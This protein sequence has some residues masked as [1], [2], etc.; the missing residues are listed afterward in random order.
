MNA[1]DFQIHHTAGT[2]WGAAFVRELDLMIAANEMASKISHEP[3]YN[4]PFHHALGLRLAALDGGAELKR[5]PDVDLVTSGDEITHHREVNA[6]ID[7][8]LLDKPRGNWA[9][10]KLSG[11]EGDRYD[12]YVSNGCGRAETEACVKFI[13]SRNTVP[14]FDDHVM[15]GHTLS[16]WAYRRRI[17]IANRIEEHCVTAAELQVG[18]EV[19]D[20]EMNGKTFSRI[21]YAGPEK[22]YYS[23]GGDKYRVIGRR[24]GVKPTSYLVDPPM[25]R[26]FFGIPLVMPPEFDDAA[27]AERVIDI[28]RPAK[29]A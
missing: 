14:A 16:A 24:A 17:E 10:F 3:L 25:L 20:I 19:R 23:G 7:A 21:A 28:V 2:P 29:A 1:R 22:G 13:Y 4:S 27:N 6:L 9:V 8:T 15:Y 26:R 5:L 18:R 12:A 11:P